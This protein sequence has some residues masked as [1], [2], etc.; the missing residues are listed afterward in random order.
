MCH[1]L[2][3]APLI[4]LVLFFVLHWQRALPPYIVIVAGS[5]AIYWKIMLSQRRKPTVGKRAMIGDSAVVV[6]VEPRLIDVRYH[7]EVWRAVSPE[8][9][10]VGQ[11]VV[12]R[13]VEGLTL[14]VSPSS[15]ADAKAPE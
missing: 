10:Q 2:L 13:D 5:L 8:P 1:L 3:L 14:K 11:R 6:K 4:G 7:D 15:P 12:I 9:L